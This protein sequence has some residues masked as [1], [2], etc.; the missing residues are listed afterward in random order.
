MYRVFDKNNFYRKEPF[1]TAKGAQ[2]YALNLS[3]GA[4][5][6]YDVH[7]IVDTSTGRVVSI[8]ADGSVWERVENVDGLIAA[9]DAAVKWM[10]PTSPTD[11]SP[12]FTRH[13]EVRNGLIDAMEKIMEVRDANIEAADDPK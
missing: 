13:S 4:D 9:A 1:D 3:S 8:V 10:G 12:S 7:Y 5:V 6:H 2:D 11:W